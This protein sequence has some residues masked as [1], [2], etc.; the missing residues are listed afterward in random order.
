MDNERIWLVVCAAEI[1]SLESLEEIWKM[2]N[3]LNS[4]LYSASLVL[5]T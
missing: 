1:G 4:E 5:M 2:K 3:L